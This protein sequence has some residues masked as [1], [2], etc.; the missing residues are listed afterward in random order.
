[1]ANAFHVT[2]VSISAPCARDVLLRIRG[3]VHIRTESELK[4]N[5]IKTEGDSYDYHIQQVGWLGGH[6][7]AQVVAYA[8][9]E[10]QSV[11]VEW[12]VI[13]NVHYWPKADTGQMVAFDLNLQP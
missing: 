3:N 12:D 2:P 9:R 13:V 7:T 4:R 11:D 5:L 6:I 10:I 8:G 1:M